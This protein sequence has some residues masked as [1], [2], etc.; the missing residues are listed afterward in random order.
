MEK[1]KT[2]R[3]SMLLLLLAMSLGAVLAPSQATAQM[4]GNWV[5][6]YFYPNNSNTPVPFRFR[7][8]HN[9]APRF[10]A[11]TSEPATFGDG[12]ARRLTANVTGQISKSGI[13]SFAKTYDGSGG[14]THTVQYEGRMRG[15]WLIDGSWR[16][17]QTKGRFYMVRY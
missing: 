12:T 15:E 14:Q 10:A 6:H 2:P 5:G 4:S 7:V 16:I 3:R 17:G 9:P 13:V 11:R 8:T 1:L